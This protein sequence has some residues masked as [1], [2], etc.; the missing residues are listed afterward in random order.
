MT[1]IVRKTQKIFGSTSGFEEISQYG[2][3]ANGTPNFTLDPAVI[4]ALT[5]F[6]NGWFSGVIGA[7]S[8]A[9]ED[10]NALFYLVCYQLAYIMQEGIAEW[11]SGTTYFIGSIVNDGSGILY[12]SLSDNNLNNAVTTSSWRQ[13]V[14]YTKNAYTA[15]SI[16]IPSGYT[17]MNPNLAIP[18]SATWIVQSGGSLMSISKLTVGSGSTVTMQP[19]STGRVI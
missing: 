8:P 18:S 4:Q 11:D 14:G 16:T 12:V 10:M 19:G 17:L 5:Q 9:E 15:T 13:V 6:T 2:S 1:K 7:N 3:L